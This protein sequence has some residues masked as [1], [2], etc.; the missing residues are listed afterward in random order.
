MRRTHCTLSES[1]SAQSQV[2]DRDQVQDRYRNRVRDRVSSRKTRQENSRRTFPKILLKQN[3]HSSTSSSTSRA[4]PPNSLLCMRARAAPVR[5]AEP[6]S[7]GPQLEGRRFRRLFSQSNSAVD[8]TVMRLGLC[9]L[10]RCARPL[11]LR[12]PAEAGRNLGLPRTSSGPWPPQNQQ[13]LG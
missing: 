7:A 2:R 6:P 13:P 8:D 5:R 1:S 11:L 4:S 12:R 9:T 3:G 10:A